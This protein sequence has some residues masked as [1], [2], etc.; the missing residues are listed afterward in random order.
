MRV[1]PLDPTWPGLAMPAAAGETDGVDLATAGATPDDRAEVVRGFVEGVDG[2][3]AA[4][5]CRTNHW[6]GSFASSAGQVVSGEATECGVSG[7]A[8]ADGADGVARHAPLS[9]AELDGAALGARAAAKARAWADPVELPAG[10]YE[11]VLEPA[12]VADLLGNLASAGFNGKA[13]NERTSFVHVGEDQFDPSLSLVDDPLEVGLAY[14]AEGTP[15]QRLA[16]VESG[17]TVARG[18]RPAYGRGGR[19]R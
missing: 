13:V 18:P 7:I 6:T 1:A 16:L 15:R 11:V 4:G 9:I 8:R 10:R 17:R 14:D 12:A 2:L 19:R 5:Y 3:E